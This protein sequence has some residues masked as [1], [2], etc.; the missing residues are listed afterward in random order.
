MALSVE[1]VIQIGRQK[2]I[3]M[4]KYE[5]KLR[6]KF[7]QTGVP[8]ET[9]GQRQAPAVPTQ[10]APP[11]PSGMTGNQ[12]INALIQKAMSG[13]GVRQN[14]GDALSI[15]GGGKP[16]SSQDD[17]SK[18]YAQEAIKKQFEDPN[19]KAMNFAL[20]ESLLK[21]RQEAPIQRDE[22]EGRLRDFEIRK[23]GGN[24]RNELN[25][26]QYIKRFREMNAAATGID[27]ILEDTLSRQDNQSKNVGD[28]ALITMYNKILD[29]L[30]VVRESEYARTPEG[31]S[32]MNRIS[33][34]VQKVASGGA[35]LTDQDRVEIARAAKVLINNAGQLYNQQIGQTREL[36]GVYGVPEEMVMTGFQDFSPYDVDK[37]YGAPQQGGQPAQAPPQGG[38]SDEQAYAEYLKIKGQR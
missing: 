31:Q 11:Q 28:Q 29:P 14:I 34:F 12:D 1:E 20:K 30:S 15:L 10:T 23:Q 18:L 37:Q 2:G 22:R 36:A 33:G 24:L 16:T 35:G 9:F 5:G 26:N 38:L 4:S 17:L 25:Q 19:E 6:Q 8:D 3:D 7:A 27:S 13:G 32:L 21:N